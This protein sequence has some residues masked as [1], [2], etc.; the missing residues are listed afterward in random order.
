MTRRDSRA[1]ADPRAGCADGAHEPSC[2]GRTGRCAPASSARS[3]SAAPSAA[4]GPTSRAVA[5]YLQAAAAA[6]GRRCRGISTPPSTWPANPDIAKAGIDPLL[7]FIDTGIAELRSPHPLID[8]RYIAADDPL[9]LGAPPGIEA[10]IDL[11]EYDL[12]PPEPLFRPAALPRAGRLRIAPRHALLRHFLQHGLRAGRTPNPFLDPGLVRRAQRRTCRTI[13]TW[14]CAISSPRAT[15]RAAPPGPRLRR[16]ALPGALHRRG[17]LRRA[18][19]AGTTCMHGRPRAARCTAG[20][21]APP[22]RRRPGAGDGRPA[23]A[24]RC[25]ARSSA[26]SPTCARAFE[27]ARQQRK[28][29]VAAAAAGAGAHPPTRR[30]DSPGCRLPRGEARRALSILVPVFNEIDGHGG[31]P[32]VDSA[33]PA[34][35]S[36][37]EVVLADDAPPTP[38]WR[39][40][41]GCP[42]LVIVRQPANLGFLAQLQ[43]RLRALPRR[44]CAAAQ[45]RRPGA[46]RRASTAWSPRSTPTARVAAAGPKIIYPERPAAG[47]RLLRPAERR[48]RHGRPVRRPRRRPATASTATSPTARARR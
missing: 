24:G 20:R 46:A 47:G 5:A 7:H 33:Q 36:A 16:P 39:C 44:L 19:A 43:R 30:G 12:A 17:R 14:R 45:Q 42:N 1:A 41:A 4:A 40:S 48:E 3:C 10:L 26:P 27:A 28:D 21:T 11:L 23:A 25:R 29:A 2:S 8:L 13:P 9:V 34:A 31:V 35:R 37:F 32:A 22:P 6:S 15:P 18:A 38:T